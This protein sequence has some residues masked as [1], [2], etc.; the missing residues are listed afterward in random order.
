MQMLTSGQGHADQIVF[1]AHAD[2]CLLMQTFVC[3][4]LY[5]KYK[6]NMWR[7]FF[8]D[9]TYNFAARLKIKRKKEDPVKMSVGSK[10]QG[11]MLKD[12][13]RGKGYPP[14]FQASVC[15]LPYPERGGGG[16]QALLMGRGREGG[17]EL[18]YEGDGSMGFLT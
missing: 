12:L 17:K 15:F 5:R 13:T 8:P 10:M 2:T 4:P 7:L 11:A 16:K 9:G 14:L 3:S 6:T 18:Q 1:S